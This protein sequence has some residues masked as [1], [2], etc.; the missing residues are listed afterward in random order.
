MFVF[1]VAFTFAAATAVQYWHMAHRPPTD[2]GSVIDQALLRPGFDYRKRYSAKGEC[3]PP[4]PWPEPVNA[5]ALR[6]N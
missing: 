5:S 2:N 3:E 4:S 6:R 1:G